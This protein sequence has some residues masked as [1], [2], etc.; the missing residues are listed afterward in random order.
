MILAL[1]INSFNQNIPATR[2]FSGNLDSSKVLKQALVKISI[3]TQIFHSQ[4][5]RSN[6]SRPIARLNSLEAAASRSEHN[7]PTQR[8]QKI[9]VE[10]VLCPPKKHVVFFINSKH[11]RNRDA[12]SKE[13]ERER[14]MIIVGRWRRFFVPPRG[15]WSRSSFLFFYTA[16]FPIPNNQWWKPFGAFCIHRQGCSF[17][18]FI[19]HSSRRCLLFGV[20]F[21]LFL[22]L[23]F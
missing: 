17:T 4:S 10:R 11:I 20:L 1:S 6:R 14:E 21:F 18:F 7:A 19:S 8:P 16:R 23:L 13:L 22:F 2:K 3:D 15:A 9:K 12:H 5:R